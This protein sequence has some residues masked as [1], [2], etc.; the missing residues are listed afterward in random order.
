MKPNDLPDLTVKEL[1]D[2]AIAKGVAKAAHMAKSELIA[3]LKPQLKSAKSA[4]SADR[5]TKAPA[6]PATKPA[7]EAPP[8]ET[9]KRTQKKATFTAARSQ[10]AP[11]HF[12]SYLPAAGPSLAP[13]PPLPPAPNFSVSV[14]PSR[15]AASASTSP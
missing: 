12:C 7:A 1:R 14:V 2:L 11:R 9:V 15:T 13:T 5:T 4:K 6:K 3:A 8:K 10:P